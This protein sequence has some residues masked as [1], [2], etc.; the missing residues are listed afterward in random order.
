MYIGTDNDIERITYSPAY[1]AVPIH[2]KR[3]YQNTEIFGSAHTGGCNMAF[4]DGH[5][6]VVTYDVDPLVHAKRGDRTGSYTTG[7][8]Q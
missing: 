1:D 4:C 5:V 7:K 2:D 6:E 8:L 3:G